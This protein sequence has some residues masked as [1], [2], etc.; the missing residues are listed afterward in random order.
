MR[1]E[2][3]RMMLPEH[4]FALNQAKASEKKVERPLLSD[5]QKE[6]I[7]LLINEAITERHI[8][9]INY[10]KDGFIKKKIATP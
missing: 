8:V 9:E 1:W 6:E 4:V 2:S 10:Y 7:E 3:S 5:E